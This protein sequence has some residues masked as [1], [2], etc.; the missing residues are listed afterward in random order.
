MILWDK[1]RVIM[2]FIRISQV[3]DRDFI[4]GDTTIKIERKYIVQLTHG[5]REQPGHSNYIPD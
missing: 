3:S 4:K 5:Y 1:D 2:Y